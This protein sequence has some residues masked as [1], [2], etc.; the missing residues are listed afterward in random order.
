MK[1]TGLT[2]CTAT[3]VVNV[4]LANLPT[5]PVLQLVNT[6][7]CSGDNIQLNTPTYG[8]SNVTYQWFL[9]IPG[10]ATLMGTTG[11]PNLLYR[12]QTPEPT[13]FLQAN[14]RRM[15]LI[16]FRGINRNGRGTPCGAV[17]SGSH[18]LCEGQPIVF[19][20]FSQGTGMIYVPGRGP[21]DTVIICKALMPF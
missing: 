19:G 7:L 13:S 17:G 20:T 4:D 6:S 5:Q 21:M 2:G 12:K 15:Y 9:G 1:I 16:E 8:G 18:Q 14:C 10:S 11:Q 3:G